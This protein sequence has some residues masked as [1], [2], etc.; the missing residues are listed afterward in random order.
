[1]KM[2]EE[3]NLIKRREDD[4]ALI[5]DYHA[6]DKYGEWMY[7]IAELARKHKIT[8]PT[9]YAILRRNGANR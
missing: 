2:R 7:T 8:R 1:M 3:L 9:V 5:K 6:K 4:R